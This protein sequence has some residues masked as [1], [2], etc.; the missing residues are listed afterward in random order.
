[1]TET[2]GMTYRS[3]NTSRREAFFKEQSNKDEGLFKVPILLGKL[4]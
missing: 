1:M 3:L 4:Y 2:Y